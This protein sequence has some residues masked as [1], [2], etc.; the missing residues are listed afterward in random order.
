MLYEEFLYTFDWRFFS[1]RKATETLRRSYI[2]IMLPYFEPYE[3]GMWN[4]KIKFYVSMKGCKGQ[5][6]LLRFMAQF[7]IYSDS[8]NFEYIAGIS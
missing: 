2:P 6:D 8:L 5:H 4:T 7:I 1:V 3:S